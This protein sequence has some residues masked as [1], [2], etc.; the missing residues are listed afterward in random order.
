VDANQRAAWLEW[1]RTNGFGGSDAAAA[2]GLSKF[3]SQTQL[4][5]E[6]RGEIPF[7][8]DEEWLRWR[9]AMEDP[10]LREYSA[11]TG[12]VVVRPTAPVKSEDHPFM[13]TTYDGVCIGSGGASSNRVVQAKTANVKEGWGEPGSDE[14]PDD[15]WIQVQHEMAV[16]KAPVADIP[17]LFYF[18]RM[19]IYTV[20]ADPQFQA[21]MIEQER[22]LWSMVHS[23]AMP[24]VL[25]IKDAQARWG[26]HSR[27]GRI[28]AN[29][30][31]LAAIDE[32][33]AVDA[34]ADDLEIRKEA[35]KLV[36]MSALGDLEAVASDDGELLLT[37]K[38]QAGRRG[39][40]SKRLQAEYPEAYAAC[41]K[42][43]TPFR[44]MLVK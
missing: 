32:L 36:I 40:D 2:M 26:R 13:F 24:P 30:E 8:E 38:A 22:A 5:L 43:G 19:E 11:R 21:T 14:V 27:L 33:K 3:K 1:R 12:R 18:S 31:V 6:K 39:L 41:V 35:A 29:A 20:V 9:L 16:A 10:I 25:S 7:G 17:V 28:I 4:V 34:A 23:D 15:Y 37:W 42:Q 44:T